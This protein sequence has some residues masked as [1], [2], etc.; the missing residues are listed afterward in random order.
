MRGSRA[1]APAKAFCPRFFISQAGTT[2]TMKVTSENKAAAARA[3][4]ALSRGPITPEGKARS[5]QNALQHGLFSANVVLSIENEEDFHAMFQ[6]YCDYYQPVGRVEH[7]LIY[8]LAACVWRMARAY[9][10]ETQV[11]DKAA[12][13]FTGPR[14]AAERLTE[15][16]FNV[17]DSAGAKSLDR[18]QARLD[19]TQSRL[20]HD[21]LLLR[22]QRKSLAPTADPDPE[23]PPQ[24]LRNE[25]ITPRVSN[26]SVPVDSPK[27]LSTC[28]PAHS[29]SG[30]LTPDSSLSPYNHISMDTADVRA[31]LEKFE[32][33]VPWMYRCTG[34]EVTV[35]I[36]H[37]IHSA[38]DAQKLT[39]DTGADQAA[40]AYA[41]IAGA[42]KGQVAKNYAPLTTC[43][44]SNDAIDALTAADIDAFTAQLRAALPKFDTYPAPAQAALFDMAYNLGIG[45]LKKFPHMLAAVDA[46]DWEAAAQQSHRNG[47]QDA[48]NNETA[49]LFRQCLG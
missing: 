21:F 25:P 42:P 16:Y 43:R 34:G 24:N 17:S 12:G 5:S 36:G 20:I 48:R 29:D 44:M 33:R 10:M 26:K 47:I 31:R 28:A 9:I 11:M 40:A 22:R 7:D 37:A 35:G 46:G 23:P 19:R 32:G 1:S 6:D 45:G 2:I 30:L 39:W 38:A 49:A 3:N 27:P 13:M 18:F 8:Q 14:P 15:G 41:V 4:G